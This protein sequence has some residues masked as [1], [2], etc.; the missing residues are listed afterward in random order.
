MIISQRTSFIGILIFSSITGLSQISY[1]LRFT[2]STQKKVQV[3]I[4]P[5]KPMNDSLQL[6]M[7]RYIAGGYAAYNFHHYI[8]N[9]V[10]LTSQDSMIPMKNGDF[11]I[12]RWILDHHHRTIKQISY[13]V[14]LGRME[15]EQTDM[16]S[17]SYVRNHFVGILNY[18]IFGWI[19]GTESEPVFYR[20]QTF[21]NWPIF[22]TIQPK[23]KMPAGSDIVECRN[24]HELADGQ[25]MLGPAM[26]IKEYQSLRPLFVAE[27]CETKDEYI[28]NY[29]NRAIASLK[30]LNDYFG[31]IPFSYYTVVTWA[32]IPAK[33]VSGASLAMEHLSSLTFIGDTSYLSVQKDTGDINRYIFGILHHM[34]HAYIPLR[35]YGDGYKPYVTEMP[36]LI[37][38]IWFNEGFIWFFCK[39]ILKQKWIDNILYDG[40][41][42]EIPAIKQLGLIE[43]SGLASLQ[44]ADDFRLG[45][46]TFSRGAMMASE[47]NDYLIKQS[48]GKKSMKDVFRYL[49]YWSDQHKRAFTLEEFP[50]LL[51]ESTHFDLSSIYDK[52]LKPLQ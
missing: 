19:D 42:K 26:R 49:F 12:P 43:L 52:W 24:Y 31:R 34:G 41:Y 37:K 3:E 2:D 11:G 23:E 36:L 48:H 39:D 5:G 38:N 14:D 25:T 46:A 40:V 50:K 32:L 15:L 45:I 28:D 29:G 51:N 22:S 9:V 47:M 6:I 13:T 4:V 30:L 18:S 27:F 20:I 10:A 44:Y 21:S 7:P 8:Q 33:P 1:T 17:S 16:G 35:C